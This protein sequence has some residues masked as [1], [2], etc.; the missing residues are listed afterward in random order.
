MKNTVVFTFGRMNPPTRGHAKLVST[1]IE[2]AKQLDADHMVY[3]SFSQNNKTDPL[4]WSFKRRV[5]ESVFRGVNISSD[6]DIKNP[7][8]ALEHLK[9]H[10]KRIVMIAGSDQ[11][12]EYTK[13][14]SGYAKEWGVDFSVVSA[15]ARLIESAGVDGI[16]ATKMRGYALAN[17]SKAFNEGLP[18]GLPAGVR[19]LVLVNTRRGLKTT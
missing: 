6:P 17:N 4:E 7:Y 12:G 11:A 19:R 9:D 18:S 13:R 5:C 8:I 10:Y 14:F 1:V 15:G 16:S 2:T 3:L